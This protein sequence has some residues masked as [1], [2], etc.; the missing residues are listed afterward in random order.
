MPSYKIL[1]ACHPSF[2][3]QALQV[4]DKIGTMLPCNVIIVQQRIEGVEVSVDPVASMQAIEN[5]S[6]QGHSRASESQV[7]GSNR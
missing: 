6:L 7:E 3:Y 2:A 5:P 1:G 4:E